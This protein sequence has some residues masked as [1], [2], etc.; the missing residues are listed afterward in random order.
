M[1]SQRIES[2]Y[3]K[4]ISVPVNDFCDLFFIFFF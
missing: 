4:E 1:S 3:I 2:L